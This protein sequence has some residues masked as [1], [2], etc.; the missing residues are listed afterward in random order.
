MDKRLLLNAFRSLTNKFIKKPNNRIDENV[1]ETSK[2]SCICD[3]RSDIS[4]ETFQID[5]LNKLCRI[6]NSTIC[7]LMGILYDLYI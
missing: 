5:P 2:W 7:T 3:V 6:P 4:K 1:N